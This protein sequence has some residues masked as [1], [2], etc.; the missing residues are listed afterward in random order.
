PS[1]PPG[2]PELPDTGSDAALMGAAAIS[3]AL[4]VGGSVV[5]LRGGRIARRH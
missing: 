4:I 2:H 5:Y 3:A 1:T